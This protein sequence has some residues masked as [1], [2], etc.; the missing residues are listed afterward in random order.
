MESTSQ[1]SHSDGSRS[2]RSEGNCSSNSGSFIEGNITPEYVR[3]MKTAS[4]RLMCS[5]RDNNLISFGHYQIKDYDSGII[6]MQIT[7]EQNAM[8]DKYARQEEET[9]NAS[10]ETR[11]IKYSFGPDFL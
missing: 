6:L 3:N 2:Y 4:D 5:L 1:S 8:A 11:T 9:G 7:E 10:I